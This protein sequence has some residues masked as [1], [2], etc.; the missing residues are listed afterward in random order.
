MKR[1]P[2][3]LLL[4]FFITNTYSQSYQSQLK[5]VN[6]FLKTFDSGY[7]GYL[8]IKD[9]YLYDNFPSGKYCKAKLNDLTTATVA[10]ANRKVALKCKSATDC[11]YSTYTDSYH[12][13]FPFSSSTDFNTKNLIDM[14]DNLL[15][16]YTLQNPERDKAANLRRHQ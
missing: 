16:A 10:E 8:E 15:D 11:V 5:K 3:F 2:F 13:E 12:N 14:L 4:I 6:E 1:T 9:G 7:Y